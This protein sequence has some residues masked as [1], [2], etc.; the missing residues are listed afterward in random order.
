MVP[1]RTHPSAR[2]QSAPE[3]TAATSTRINATR[4]KGLTRVDSMEAAE[5]VTVNRAISLALPAVASVFSLEPAA[6]E[7]V[8]LVFAADFRLPSVG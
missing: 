8:E 7:T 4:I 6:T 3:G 5:A 1:G 2:I